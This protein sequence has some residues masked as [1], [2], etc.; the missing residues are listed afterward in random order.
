MTFSFN[1]TLVSVA[2]FAIPPVLPSPAINFALVSSS[3]KHIVASDE[4]FMFSMLDIWVLKMV[5][6]STTAVR[7]LCRASRA[8]HSHLTSTTE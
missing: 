3:R 7:M 4:F 5:A 2:C 6:A 1:F 8:I